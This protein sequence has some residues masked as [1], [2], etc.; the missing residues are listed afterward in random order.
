[1]VEHVLCVYASELLI[2]VSLTFLGQ[3]LAFFGEDRLATLLCSS[4]RFDL[5]SRDVRQSP[6]AHFAR[7]LVFH[8][9]LAQ[10]HFAVVNCSDAAVVS[11]LLPFFNT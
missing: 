2:W 11:V 6:A 4:A 10:L 3:G 7:L 9:T 5:A 8:E 1:V